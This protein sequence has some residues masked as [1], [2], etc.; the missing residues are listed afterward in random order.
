MRYVPNASARQLA[1]GR[2]DTIGLAVPFS[3]QYFLS[4]E[5]FTELIRGILSITSEYG[6]GLQL[7]LCHPGENGN[8]QIITAA[9][10]Q[11]IDG[12]IA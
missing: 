4:D 1:T 6:M 12:V 3:R 9:R 10:Q 8:E 2:S 7:F 11:K 5:F